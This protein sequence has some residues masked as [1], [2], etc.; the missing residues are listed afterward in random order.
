VCFSSQRKIALLAESSQ[1]IKVLSF[2]KVYEGNIEMSFEFLSLETIQQ[3]ARDYGYWAVFFGILLENLGVPLPG[4]TI[5]IAGGFLAGS[6]ELNYWYVL[7]SAI[8]GATVGGNFGYA[9]G[10]YGG[11]PLLLKL[12][13]IFRFREEQ[14]FDL[15]EKFSENAAK[16][17][18]LGRFIALLRIFASPLAGIAEMPFLQ[19]SFFNILGAASWASVMVSLSYFL[20]QVVSLE[21]LVGWAAQ[22]AV[23]ALLLTVA[24]IAIPIWLESRN[25][26]KTK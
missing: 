8:A 19:F 17:V 26:D 16:A 5:T 20:G 1:Y 11:W 6:G 21:K 12:G 18:F 7:G 24:W 10:R 13:K 23:V 15:K 2:A 3:L 4:E 14:L 25:L 22:F 9:I